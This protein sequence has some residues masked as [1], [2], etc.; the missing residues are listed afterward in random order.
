MDKETMKQSIIE[1]I[2]RKLGDEFHI[3]VHT[4]LKTNRKLDGL[5]IMKEG[6]RIAP[7][8][9]MDNY[10]KKLENGASIDAV[11][12]DILEKYDGAK[13]LNGC[14]EVDNIMDCY[15]KRLYVELVNRSLNKE[16]LE[17]IP[18]SRFLDDFAVVVRCM[19]GEMEG[20][21]MSFLVRNE[22]MDTW[23]I[24]KE[25]LISIAIQ[26]TRELMGIEIRNMREVI[27]EIFPYPVTGSR[28][29]MGI[30]V[31][32]NREKLSGASTALFDDV[33]KDF[34]E[35]HG[36]LYVVFSSM[37]EVLLFLESDR[38]GIDEVTR[39]NRQ[40]NEEELE[41]GEVLGTRAYYYSKDKGFVV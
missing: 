28:T 3:S 40:V 16:L 23:R 41:E 29:D 22:H 35:K 12:E 36:N 13:M 32:T 31:M 27:E 26:N 5:E 20:G 34:A 7:V 15:R 21:R 11:V 37:H 8:I 10:Y 38:F 30:W 25:E 17:V 2:S 18:H 14:F 33:L 24:G 6:N 39:I 9:Y 4:A 1:A 19:V